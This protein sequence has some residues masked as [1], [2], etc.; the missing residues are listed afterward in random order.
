M[1]RLM[2]AGPFQWPLIDSIVAAN[3][4]GEVA[5]ESKML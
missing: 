3:G 4:A 1:Q 5:D 2:R